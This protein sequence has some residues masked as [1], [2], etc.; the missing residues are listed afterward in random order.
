MASARRFIQYSSLPEPVTYMFFSWV[1][2][3]R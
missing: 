1:D 2:G 3:L